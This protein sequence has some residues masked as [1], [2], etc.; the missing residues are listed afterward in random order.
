MPC[1]LVYAAFALAIA[2]GNIASGATVMLAFGVGTVPA[3][4]ATGVASGR[5][6]SVYA[7]RAWLRRT[8]GALVVVFGVI[9]VA[10]ASVSLGEPAPVCAC[11]RR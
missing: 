7:S 6:M 4:V 10:S 2:S 5:A 8:A 11:H 9:D 1:G 3:M